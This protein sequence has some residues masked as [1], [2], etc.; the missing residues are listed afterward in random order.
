MIFLL[1][2]A[3]GV[4]V[5]HWQH[6]LG[7]LIELCSA[8]FASVVMYL[9]SVRTTGFVLLHLFSILAALCIDDDIVLTRHLKCFIYFSGWLSRKIFVGVSSVAIV[10]F[11]ALIFTLWFF[12]HALAYLSNLCCRSIPNVDTSVS[13]WTRS[14][15][16][17]WEDYLSFIQSIFFTIH[18]SFTRFYEYLGRLSIFYTVYLLHNLSIFY[19]IY[20]S[21]TQSE[22]KSEKWLVKNCRLGI[23][24]LLCYIFLTSRTFIVFFSWR[25]LFDADCCCSCRNCCSCWWLLFDVDGFYNW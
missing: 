6:F 18:L 24:S 11:L 16:N 8:V 10:F 22:K 1:F 14:S 21:F 9:S 19:I 20:L 15:M 4:L 3:M 17:I 13:S 12:L 2:L 25:Q 7:K 5:R 23:M